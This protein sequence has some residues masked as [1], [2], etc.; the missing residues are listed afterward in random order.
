MSDTCDI[1]TYACVE[2]CVAGSLCGCHRRPG[3]RYC[4]QC[5]T[6]SA[7]RKTCKQAPRTSLRSVSVLR[8]AKLGPSKTDT[9]VKSCPH[10]FPALQKHTYDVRM[11]EEIVP[12]VM[13]MMMVMMV[14]MVMAMINLSRGIL[15]DG[16]TQRGGCDRERKG[17]VILM[18]TQTCIG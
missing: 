8:P 10:A 15:S 14:V 4:N 11:G 7:G 12:H 3:R 1:H 16:V 18:A 13:M 17:Q 5:G 9:R 2:E 6:Q